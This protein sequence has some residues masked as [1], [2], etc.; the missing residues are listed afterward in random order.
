MARAKK[1][2]KMTAA[3]LSRLPLSAGG[4][5]LGMLGRAGGWLLT[6]I[7]ELGLF[8]LGQFLRA[9]IAITTVAV[10]AGLSLLAGSN[11]LFFQT[12]RHP[13]PLFFAPA[14]AKAPPVRVEAPPPAVAPV[15]PAPRPASID[16]QTT[17][18]LGPVAPTADTIGNEQVM[19]L[20]QKLVALKLLDDAPDGK[21]GRRTA[22]AVKA[23]ETKVGMRADGRL[24]AELLA[25]VL[26]A[27]GGDAGQ[28]APAALSPG[29]PV[30]DPIGALATATA[31][32]AV[33]AAPAA[34]V[35]PVPL[36]PLPAARPAATN[37]LAPAPTEPA[38]APQQP[39]TAPPAP[40]ETIEIPATQPAGNLT[41]AQRLA[42]Q[43]GT[44]PPQ[45]TAPAAT[46]PAAAPASPVLQQADASQPETVDD[47]NGSTDPVLIGKIQ[48]GLASLGFL[49]AR[50]DGVPGEGTAKAIRNFEVF[51]DYKVTGLATHK[52]L[53]LLVQHGAVI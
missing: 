32:P 38:P 33:E 37:T 49:G 34:P 47:S 18:S 2:R 13:A 23:F 17:G 4:S 43:M 20:Q 42:Q 6:Q 16:S 45:Q 24:T 51:Y 22:A 12:Q 31:G 29:R 25:A 53:N 7:M 21:F 9:P 3:T 40:P 28:P 50:I 8:V 26:A 30:A 10:L 14:P 35:A 41:A 39:A 46:P 1:K 48:R 19:A 11:A 15:I 52:L 44:L 36:A 5:A 27:P